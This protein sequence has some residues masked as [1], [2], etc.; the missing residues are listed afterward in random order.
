MYFRTKKNDYG[1][2]IIVAIE[3]DATLVSTSGNQWLESN[4]SD[5]VPG[6]YWISGQCVAIGSDDYDELVGSVI[7]AARDAAD[8][9]RREADEAAAAASA[10]EQAEIRRLLDEESVVAAAT[11]P[12]V[13]ERKALAKSAPASGYV[14]IRENSLGV[15]DINA[16]N[17][18]IWEEV[19][20]DTIR[21]ISGVENDID[22]DP[23][24]VRFPEPITYLEG[25]PEEH[26]TAFI[27]LA[28][29][30]KDAYLAHWK[31]V[32]ADQQAWVAHMKTVLGV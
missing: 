3:T 8:T 12:T 19:V 21:T 15:P 22:P 30:D 28:D 18:A 1:I 10:A 27:L 32:L 31:I 11:E 23:A 13:E 17:L 5:C 25:T 7:A 26:T 29:E 4:D 9:A 20:A 2:D 16:D 6:A 14:P 24:V